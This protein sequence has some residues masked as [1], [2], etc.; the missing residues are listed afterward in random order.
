M[1]KAGLLEEMMNDTLESALD[2]EE[3]EEES[4]EAVD[5]ILMEIAGET[6][7]QMAA[8]PRRQKQVGMGGTGRAAGVVRGRWRC[9]AG[10][11]WDGFQGC[12]CMAGG[13]GGAALGLGSTL[14]M[15]VLRVVY[16]SDR[17]VSPCGLYSKA[18]ELCLPPSPRF[19]CVVPQ[20]QAVAPQEAAEEEEDDLAAR[21]A[22]VRS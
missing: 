9:L 5:R 12:T 15:P 4:E 14:V 19:R 11:V 13:A 17:P 1:T 22:A 21:L 8:A 10:S 7:G 16:S 18:P 3:M 2:S 6:L 20:A